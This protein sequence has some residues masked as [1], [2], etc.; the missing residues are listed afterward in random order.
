MISFR[1]SRTKQ[2]Y[3]LFSSVVSNIN[4]IM[5]ILRREKGNNIFDPPVLS[6]VIFLDRSKP[7][8]RAVGG[9]FFSNTPFELVYSLAINPFIKVHL[10]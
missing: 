10:K 8:G 1:H 2:G 7:D 4:S 5:R 6:I 3:A 9:T